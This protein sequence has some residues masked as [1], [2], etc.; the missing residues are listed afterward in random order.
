MRPILAL[1]FFLLGI[2]SAASE[3]KHPNT[4][5]AAIDDALTAAD[6]PSSEQVLIDRLIGSI[7]LKSDVTVPTLEVIEASHEQQDS[8][9]EPLPSGEAAT[10]PTAIERDVE[11]LDGLCNTL[12]DSAQHNDLPV[13]FF[14]NLIWQESR[15]R[16]DA[17]SP[18]GAQGIAQF[19]PRVAAEVGLANPFD[20]RQALPASARLLRELRDRF[21]NLGFVAAAYN[22]GPHRVA[23]WLL[24]GGKLPRE[25]QNYVVSITGRSVEAW[26]KSPVDDSALKFARPLPCR[27]LPA[28]AGIEQAQAEQIPEPAP[29]QPQ[30]SHAAAAAAAEPAPAA[31]HRFVWRPRMRVLV[32]HVVV[33][34]LASVMHRGVQAEWAVPTQAAAGPAPAIATGGQIMPRVIRA[35]VVHTVTGTYHGGRI[36]ARHHQPQRVTHERR[37]IAFGVAR[38]RS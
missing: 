14:A 28:F 24:H 18:V 11:S 30:E 25:T 31:R 19:M 29:E 13:P 23:E 26:R 22:A 35:Q 20:P 6:E 2:S 1:G 9:D 27:E 4:L 16:H 32:Q 8:A 36:E 7:D 38:D 33:R 37:R 3:P 15:L 34:R 21:R 12:F 10:A 5:V 17:V